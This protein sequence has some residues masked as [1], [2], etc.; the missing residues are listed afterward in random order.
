MDVPLHPAEQMLE[1]ELLTP[2]APL[3]SLTLY[4]WTHGIACWS[5]WVGGLGCTHR[6]WG[7]LY[8]PPHSAAEVPRQGHNSWAVGASPSLELMALQG[9]PL[10]LPRELLVPPGLTASH[11][12]NLRSLTGGGATCLSAF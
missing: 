8:F 11:L 5:Q 12:L 3:P 1:Q 2:L 10:P 9:H 6:G 7:G 4:R